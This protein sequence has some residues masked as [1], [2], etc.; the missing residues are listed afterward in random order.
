MSAAFVVLPTTE[1]RTATNPCARLFYLLLAAD[2]VLILVFVYSFANVLSYYALARVDAAVYTVLLQLKILTT[3]SFF[4]IMLGRSFSG[5]K[6]RSLLLLVIGCILV[7]SP[8]FNKECAGQGDS[9]G[10]EKVSAFETALGV[11]AILIMVTISGYSAV[12]FESMLKKD[13]TTVWERNFQ[14]AFYSSILLLGIM[15]SE[16]VYSSTGY[17]DLFKGWTINA[18]LLAFIQAGGGMLVAAT[19]K[20][21]DAILKTL[22]TSG[23]IVLSAVVGYLVLDGPLDIFVVLG[24]ICT[25]LAIFNYTL[26]ATPTS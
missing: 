12:Y 19:L 25:I 21:A 4:V 18:F 20:Y 23:S 11:G 9:N 5:A 8:A 3:A 22:A 7:A 13:K 24:C 2:K 17:D 16:R 6:W 14:L 26:D 1:N 10:D 15:V